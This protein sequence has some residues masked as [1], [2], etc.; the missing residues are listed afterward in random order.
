MPWVVRALPYGPDKTMRP[1]K[2]RIFEGRELVGEVLDL[3][4][5]DFAVW[6]YVQY[7]EREVARL[8]LEAETSVLLAPTMPP[9]L[10]ERLELQ[11]DCNDLP[12]AGPPATL[13]TA[14]TNPVDAAPEPTQPVSSPAPM[15]D[16][17][18]APELPEVAT[19]AQVTGAPTQLVGGEDLGTNK[20]ALAEAALLETPGDSNVSIAARIG[21][22]DEL[23]RKC[24]KSLEATGKLPGTPATMRKDGNTP[25]VSSTAE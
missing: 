20:R 3:G 16:S 17:N 25:L 15:T 14:L 18:G 9:D 8:K 4:H 24:R 10:A 6:E 22:S 7:L 19:R 11:T 21:V 5:E 12:A 1:T 23:V 2:V 13:A